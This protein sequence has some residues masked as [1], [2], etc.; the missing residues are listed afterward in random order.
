MPRWLSLGFQ[1]SRSPFIREL[2][3]L[4]DHIIVIIIMIIVLVTYIMI[5]LIVSLSFYKFFSEGTYIETI[6]SV[7][8]AFLLIV[9]VVPSIK[10][11]Y[12]MEDVKYPR[13]SFKV[14]AHQ[15]Y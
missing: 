5:L 15:W 8:P 4:H 7:V 6:W 1:D 10:V 12:L 13:Y 11:L 3:F 9:L 14:V 2:R